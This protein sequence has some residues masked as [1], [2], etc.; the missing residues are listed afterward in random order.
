MSRPAFGHAIIQWLESEG[1]PWPGYRRGS[2]R[3]TEGRHPTHADQGKWQERPGEGGGD[4]VGSELRTASHLCADREKTNEAMA[5]DR[6]IDGCR[7]GLR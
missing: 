2:P 7:V 6:E 4:V 3:G 1:Q 5:S